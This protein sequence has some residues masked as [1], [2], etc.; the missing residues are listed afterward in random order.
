MEF[1]CLFFNKSLLFTLSYQPPLG[2]HIYDISLRIRNLKSHV[3]HG[4]VPV[5]AVKESD[6]AT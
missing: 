6:T 3:G 1:V 4:E 2:M 5:L